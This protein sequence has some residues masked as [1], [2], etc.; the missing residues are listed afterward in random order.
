MKFRPLIGYL[1]MVA[2]LALLIIST[3]QFFLQIRL[4]Y[5][6][7]IGVLVGFIAGVV[8]GRK[9][10]LTIAPL[11][12]NQTE[13]RGEEGY[14]LIGPRSYRWILYILIFYSLL[15]GLPVSVEDFPNIWMFNSL[16]YG[17]L[18]GLMFTY[19]FTLTVLAFKK[20]RTEGRKFLIVI[21]NLVLPPL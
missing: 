8:L 14:N 5:L 11:I 4:L 18:N 20:E 7:A 6:Y 1:I 19:F 15:I 13:M 10:W 12:M 2:A 17:C 9:A 3:W 16:V 21:G